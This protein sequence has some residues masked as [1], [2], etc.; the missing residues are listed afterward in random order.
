MAPEQYDVNLITAGSRFDGTVEF[1]NYTR[2]EGSIRGTLKGV[3]GS[4]LIVGEQGVVEGKIEGDKVII[5]GFVRGEIHATAKVTISES[6]RV[7]GQITAPS[8]EIKFGGYFD[9][10][11]SMLGLLPEQTGNA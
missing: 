2:F 1:S 8:V 6:G 7:I 9:G 5:D 11:C 3:P 10:K 4:E